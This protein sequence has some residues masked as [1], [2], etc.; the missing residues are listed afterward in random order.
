MI[1]QG[2]DVAAAYPGATVTRAV[3]GGAGS[4]PEKT[5]RPAVADA[6]SG[7]SLTY[8]ELAA[9]TGAAASGL[10]R[11]GIRPGD[12]VGLHLPGGPEFALALHA[13]TAA[14]AV[15]FPVGG[16]SAA[17]TARLLES[18][19]ART[20]I[21]WP[22]LADDVRGQERRLFCFGEEPGTEPFSAL[23]TG[24]AAPAAPVD[25]ARDSGDAEPATEAFS[26][27]G[28]TASEVAVDPGD[29]GGAE[30]GTE[31]FSARSTGVA[32]PVVPVDPAR[33]LALIVC[34]G[35]PPGPGR[36]VRLT[37]AE[38]VAA[39][40]RVA[41]AGMIGAAD[42]VLT[43]LP[44][45]G[46]LG[47][48]GVLNPGLRL[49]ATIVAFTGGRHDLLRAL[50]RWR[51]TVAVLPPSMAETLGRDR[52]VGRYDL[53]TLRAVVTV[54]GPLAA[55]DA[56]A[57]AARL[58]CPVRQAY[59]LAEAAGITHLNL[60]AAEE[61][62]LDSVGR[63]LPGVKWCVVHPRTGAGQPSYQPGELCVRLP[64]AR[65]AAVP[66]R[67]LP[68]GDS[69]F[70]DDHGRVFVLG[71]V[72]RARPEPPGEPEAVLAAHPAV[73]DAAV[74]P[75]PDEDLGLAPHAFAVVTDETSADDLLAYLDT[76][77]AG[78]RGVVAV[79]LVEE[80]PRDSGGRVR[81]RALLDR[82]GLGR[83]P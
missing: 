15:P 40:V 30:A 7:R 61:G 67:W 29:P 81:R 32:A 69:A 77:V 28:V 46:V 17:E 10:V 51:A 14:G 66:V 80:I 70:A 16:P 24:A 65:T 83:L 78:R 75:V 56:R 55:E 25:P 23:L 76:H 2:V 20:V 26:A 12:V 35:G 41:E 21:T 37:H 57:A 44:L 18:A 3:L 68:T 1:S 50:Q 48:N 22:G 45:T 60:R 5:A 59:G 62:T 64:V 47:L 19:G 6:S 27:L 74:A 31:P 54:G 34:A 58:G 11:E 43:A 38:M 36:T 82:A 13:V 8:G 72:G 52:T 49:G 39:L 9:R 79:H 53:R 4:G 63:G 71:R 73:S 33:D 42:T